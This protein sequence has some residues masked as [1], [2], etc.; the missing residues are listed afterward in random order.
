MKLQEAQE[1]NE[2]LIEENNLLKEKIEIMKSKEDELVD[3]YEVESMTV[4]TLQEYLKSLESDYMN[5]MN[6]RDAK[7]K[8]LKEEKHQKS[9]KLYHIQKE[10]EINKL[11]IKQLKYNLDTVKEDRLILNENLKVERE[12][13]S[14]K[15]KE[16]TSLQQRFCT[17]TEIE[18][19]M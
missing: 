11:E 14:C 7:I 19:V 6:N 9:L 1:Q 16:I 13:S 15:E 12:N 17:F 5:L 3:N 10:I 2:I 18:K 4:E 8:S